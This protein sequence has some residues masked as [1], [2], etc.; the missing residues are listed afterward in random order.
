VHWATCAIPPACSLDVD[1]KC[2]FSRSLPLWIQIYLSESHYWVSI[3]LSPPHRPNFAALRHLRHATGFSPPRLSG[4]RSFNDVHRQGPHRLRGRARRSCGYVLFDH[5]LQMTNLGHLG[6]SV[7]ALS[8]QVRT[9]TE[10]PFLY[11]FVSCLENVSAMISGHGRPFPMRGSKS[12]RKHLSVMLSGDPSRPDPG[13]P[14]HPPG[15][16]FFAFPFPFSLSSFLQY[17]GCY[18]PAHPKADCLII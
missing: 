14:R 12:W 2:T 8:H 11:D 13:R 18:V 3:H 16:H 9:V 6:D 7:A 17:R 5:P 10:A 4:L 15:C 1:Q